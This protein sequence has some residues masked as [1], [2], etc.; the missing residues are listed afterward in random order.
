[1]LSELS[2]AHGPNNNTNK[3]ANG[4]ANS[5]TNSRYDHVK[6]WGQLSSTH[7]APFGTKLFHLQVHT[8]DI[9][10]STFSIR[11]SAQMHNVYDKSKSTTIDNLCSGRVG[12]L[13]KFDQPHFSFPAWFVLGAKYC[14]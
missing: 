5:N 3:S 6:V 11:L 12:Y 2:C 13:N 7:D 4:G 14:I 9:C 1:M 10:L 8:A